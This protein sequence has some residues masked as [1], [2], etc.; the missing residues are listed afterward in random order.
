MKKNTLRLT[1][2]SFILSMMVTSSFAQGVPAPGAGNN[3]NGE[4]KTI[5]SFK[6][7]IGLS[8]DQETKLKALLYDEQGLIN[9]DNDKL[10]TLG[11]ELDQMIQSKQAMSDIKSKLEEISKVQ[12]DVNYINIQYSREVETI[13][14][15]DQIGKWKDIQ[16]KFSAQAKV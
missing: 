14:T 3:Q 8:D 13:L 12:V 6:D 7:E 1:G 10:R 4:V 15:P 11:G 9:A 16:K 2:L 5:F